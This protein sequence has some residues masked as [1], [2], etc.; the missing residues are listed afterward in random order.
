ML[1]EHNCLNLGTTHAY[2]PRKGSI[3]LVRPFSQG[4]LLTVHWEIPH[5]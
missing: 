3:V 1:L 4:R 2:F 5:V